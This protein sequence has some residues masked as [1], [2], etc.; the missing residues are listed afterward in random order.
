M[1]ADPLTVPVDN[2]TEATVDFVAVSINGS[3]SKRV[4][5]DFGE[6]GLNRVVDISHT[7]V[8]KGST[9]RD[10]HLV[11]F[12]SYV[13]DDGVEDLGKPISMYVVADIPKNGVSAA[14][15]NNL[16]KMVAGFLRGVSGS[17][18]P[19]LTLTGGRWL[20]GEM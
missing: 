19:D 10:R 3:S 16:L 2:A 1:F 15:K 12:T 17:A 14:Q 5:E 6:A 11:R 8:G 7:E 9:A 20:N 18:T 4:R 13:V